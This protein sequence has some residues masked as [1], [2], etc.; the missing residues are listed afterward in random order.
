[1]QGN[2][3]LDGLQSPVVSSKLR[4]CLE[5]SWPVILQALG[6][7]S[8]PANFEGQDCTKASVR[9]TYKH[10]EATCQ[11][12]MVHL[13]FEDFK[14]LWGFSLLGLFQSQHPV[15]YRSIIQ[16]AFVNTKHGG[17]SP[18]DE[19]KPPGLKLYEIVLP[20]FQFLSTESFFGAGL[21]NVDIC[22]ELLQVGVVSYSII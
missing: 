3:F 16:L 8:V 13:K 20:M 11:Y 21:L 15:L 1:M 14:F 10:T 6:L 4:P 22:K 18:R 19:V 9:I 17:N 12:S 5:E 7:D 2:L